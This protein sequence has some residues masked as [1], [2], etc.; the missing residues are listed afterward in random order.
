MLAVAAEL[1]ERG[2]DIEILGTEEGLERDLVPAAGYKMTTVPKVPIPRKPTFDWFTLPG[3][4]SKARA[5]ARETIKGACGVV[6]FG[7]YVSA[8]AYLAASKEGVPFVIHEQ[9]ARPGLAN[10]LGARTAAGVCVTF[11]STDLAAKNG[12]TEVTGLPLRAEI[13]ELTEKRATADGKREARQEA[14]DFLGLDPTL[15]TL[16]VTGG[17]LGALSVNRAMADAA[18]EM[19][20]GVQI[21]HLTGRGKAD[22]LDV[23]WKTL[24]YLPQMHHAL[25]LAD[26]VVCRA[27]AGT[28]SELAVLGL[29]AVFVPL[30]IGNG[31]QRK[32]AADSVSAGGSLL[33][34]DADFGRDAVKDVVF[35]LLVDAGR[36]AQMGDKLRLVA[37]PGAT[38]RVADITEAVCGG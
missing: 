37:K 5:I 28:V 9:N 10:K 8:P 36:L 22:S 11:P 18:P 27:G 19:P 17:S 1:D 16:L 25:A 14:A 12:V 3:R 26:L 2:F 38:K 33:I 4:I 20:E 21:L 31:E 6:G 15:P 7:G 24:E 13:Q 23:P 32:N 29:P 30:A 34:P 35:P